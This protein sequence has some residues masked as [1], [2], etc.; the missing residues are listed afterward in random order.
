MLLMVAVLALF[1]VPVA[2]IAAGGTFTDDDT[3]VFEGDIEWMA[4]NGITAGCNPPTNDHYCPDDAVTRGQMAAFM[5][6]LATKKVVDADKVDGKHASD[7]APIAVAQVDETLGGSTVAGPTTINSVSITVPSNGVVLITGSAYINANT[8]NYFGIKVVVDATE[9]AQP[10]AFDAFSTTDDDD[11]ETEWMSYTTAV[12][13]TPGTHIISQNAGQMN[14][15]TAEL[16]AGSFFYNSNSM[17]VTFIPGGT[18]SA[19]TVGT[20][21]GGSMT[22]E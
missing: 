2:A 11:D 18:V 20:S 4:A 5:K 10:V 17:T 9:I 1:V 13:V 8:D 22:G 16:E 6:R 12:A 19:S 14:A 7:I 15:G 21:G 3:S